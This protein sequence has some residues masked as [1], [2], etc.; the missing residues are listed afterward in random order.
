M[1]ISRGVLLAVAAG[2][3]AAAAAAPWLVDADR[4]RG[5]VED[6]LT[7]AAGRPVRLGPLTT[8]LWTGPGISASGIE[9]DSEGAR[10]F[11]ARRARVRFALGPLFRGR[12]VPRK[13]TI[14]D[15]TFHAGP[16]VAADAFR[17]EVRLPPDF[18]TGGAIEG[19]WGAR[20]P[21][22]RA[23]AEASFVARRSGE[24][25]EIPSMTVRCGAAALHLEGAATALA[26][27][28][29]APSVRAEGHARVEAGALEI[30]DLTFTAYGG[31]GRGSI[32][33]A[34]AAAGRPFH[35]RAEAEGVGTA[36]LL[37]AIAPKL[38][39]AIE[40][41][42]SFAF[43]VS[44]RATGDAPLDGLAGS[45]RVAIRDGRIATVGLMR[46]V[47]RLLELAGGKGIGREDTPFEHM[48]ATFRIEGGAARTDDLEFRSPD[49]D[50]D[51][52]GT[53]GLRGALGLSVVASL[54]KAA[55]ADLVA[56]T[57]QLKFRVGG[58]GRVTVPLKIRGNLGSPSVQLDLDRVIEE[59][60]SG[61]KDR[62]K[63]SLLK[64]LLGRE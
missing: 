18:A 56:K 17:L 58:D 44:G 40:G 6:R 12:V 38:G 45:A 42:G 1:R 9:V 41:T 43:E 22:L 31:R 10:L 33:A 8:T 48:T 25:F 34:L 21:G 16:R 7:E 20:V 57:P 46:Q 62:A 51:G 63:R 36:G 55:S 54:S 64:K 2:V 39:P 4:F 52:K 59:G 47:G 27:R 61:K 26:V 24:A 50:L 29:E 30:D 13:L 3:V 19:T 32:A 35:L 23:R 53:V 5:R 60:L 28:F 11:D 49:L 37:T 15:G 14:D